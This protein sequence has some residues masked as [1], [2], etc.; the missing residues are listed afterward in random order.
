MQA[1]LELV[2]LQPLLAALGPPGGRGRR[3]AERLPIAKAYFISRYPGLPVS[4]R[5]TRLHARLTDCQ[6]PLREFCGFSTRDSVPDR[7]TFSRAFRQLDELRELAGGVFRQLSDLFGARPWSQSAQSDSR[8][9]NGVHRGTDR[10]YQALR[11]ERRY[12]LHR[13]MEDFRS[14]EDV[15]QFFVKCRWPDGIRCPR[16]ESDRIAERPTRNPQPWR[17]RSC[18]HYFSVKVGTVMQCSN[19]SLRHWLTAMYLE[20]CGPK[21]ESAYVVA[22]LL[23]IDQGTALFLLHRIRETFVSE[24]ERFRGPVQ[25]DETYIGGLNKNK[26]FAKKLA[27]GRGISGKAAVVGLLDMESDRLHA[28]PL[29]EVNT[30]TVREIVRGRLEHGATLYTDQS[31]VYS[32]FPAVSASL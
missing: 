19:L 9:G 2:D 7:S 29:R 5:V 23:E 17:C 11:R 10:Y 25:A 1:A 15:E 30:A 22:D 6:D 4:R 28:Q 21:G 27:S 14:D 20:A 12:G 3:R 16:C 26:H 31:S 8:G 32:G 13:F 18:R 24:R